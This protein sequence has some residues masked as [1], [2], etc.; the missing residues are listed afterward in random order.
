M[1][2]SKFSNALLYSNK[3]VEKLAKK[4][5]NESANAVLMEM[6]AD[7]C[8]LADHT[9]GQIF[10]SKYDFDGD[11]FT[12]KD[13][14]E[15]PLESSN[16]PLKEAIKNYFDDADVS[17]AEAYETIST[18]NTEVFESSLTEAL[19]GK[20]MNNIINY[21]EIAGINE[22]IGNVK[23]T[24]AFKVYSE[25]LEEKPVDNIKIFDWVN[26]VKVSLLD[27]DKGK[28]LNKSM[29]KKAKKLKSDPDFKKKLCAASKDCLDGDNSMMEELISENISLVS[30]DTAELKETIGLSLVGD[31]TLMENRNKI[32]SIVENIIAEDEELSSK[33]D[34]VEATDKE[35]D[36][37]APEASEQDT[38]A[39]KKALEA[40]KEK[41]TDEKL[42]D[43]IDNLISSLEES[44]EVGE[45]NVGA[46]KE[47]VSV[48]SC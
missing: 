5:I 24:E 43:K 23:D 44:L 6:F 8:F 2:I 48:L 28:F 39:I 11:V 1:E 38:E 10:E 46:M 17:L 27:E 40:A 13:F 45:T 29:K 32:V 33:K 15:I 16:E 26:P 19:A 25:R 14:K 42:I 31:K 21:N 34:E 4:L 41:A 3:N 37:E 47:A 35:E 20:N 36:E 30:L 7:K 18:T 12:F 22:E 9:T